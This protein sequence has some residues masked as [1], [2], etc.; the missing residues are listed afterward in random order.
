MF[1]PTVLN[2][3]ALLV[4]SAAGFIAFKN[5][6]AYELEIDNRKQQQ[7]FLAASQERLRIAI[8]NY[9]A[10]VA[11]DKMIQEEIEGLLKDEEVQ[12][13]LNA[14]LAKEFREKS[15]ELQFFEDNPDLVNSW[16]D[17][18]RIAENSMDEIRVLD[19]EIKE[20]NTMVANREAN[21][22]DLTNK[23]NGLKQNI[24]DLKAH[25]E[26]RS[27]GRSVDGLRTRIRSVYNSW[28]F[29]TLTD[30]DK[31]GVVLNSTLDVVRGEDVIAKLLVTIVEQDTASADIVPG[32]MAPDQALM[33][34]DLV[35]PASSGVAAEPA[36]P[37]N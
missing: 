20:Y 35:V 7:A 23:D 1:K 22:D 26:S 14:A 16:R 5:K 21:L 11:E 24:A 29:V 13:E 3:L 25:I 15:E 36:L 6:K 33:I 32:S 19:K 28:G 18:V 31:K 27:G 17:K 8:E 10:T 37:A 30:G 4:L 2:V 12:K 9:D 34:G